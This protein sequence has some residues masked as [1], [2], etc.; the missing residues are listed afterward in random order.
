MQTQ[1]SSKATE[2]QLQQNAIGWVLLASLGVSYVIVGDYAGWNFGLA[3]GGWGGL[4]IATVYGALMYAAL[5]ASFAELSIQ[6]PE[7]GGGSAFAARAYGS[8]AACLAGASILAEYVGAAAIIAIFMQAYVHA[9]TGFGGPSLV[10]GVFAIF[11]GAHTMGVG[12]ALR[13]LL[14]IALIA[15]LGLLAFLSATA[16]H[17]DLTRLTDIPIT[18]A[19]GA[20]K[21]L[22][23]G[24][25]GVWA[26]LPFGTA[27]FLAVEGTALA[28]EETR[29][30]A[31]NIPRGMAAALGTLVL[32]AAS[33][34]LLAPGAAGS[35]E[36]QAVNDPLVVA[37]NAGGAHGAAPTL[38]LLVKICGAAAFLACLF[39]AMYGYSRLTFALA[40]DGYLPKWLART[41]RRQAPVAA[42]VLPGIVACGLALSNAAEQVFVLM[43]TAGTF[44]YLV[45]LPAHWVLRVRGVRAGST[46]ATW[47]TPGGIF[48]SGFAWL[49][50]GISFAACFLSAPRWATV[51]LIVLALITVGYATRRRY[52]RSA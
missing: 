17:F 22:P 38:A 23:H 37:L 33:L 9:T 24:W 44:S 29:D 51:T 19:W 8:V 35:R 7:A 39:S 25:F 42:I 14:V 46:P 34:V 20:G 41:N 11:I 5:L 6:I 32:L 49:T 31:R 12:G 45:I 4:A 48:T 26:A 3:H 36:L 16:P 43:V 18:T 27:F 21:W 52:R 30:P 40:R 28:A 10:I 2:D 15:V 47:R 1:P 50:S 13:L